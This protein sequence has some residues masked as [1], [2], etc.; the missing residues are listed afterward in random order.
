[1]FSLLFLLLFILV[2]KRPCVVAMGSELFNFL[3]M[4]WNDRLPASNFKVMMPSVTRQEKTSESK[5]SHLMSYHRMA[6][7]VHDGQYAARNNMLKK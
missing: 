6:R 1:M 7:P 3:A 5:F 2:F 4:T